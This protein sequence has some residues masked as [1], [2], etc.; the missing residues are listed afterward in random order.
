MLTDRAYR[1]CESTNSTYKSQCGVEVSN[2]E[3]P[4]MMR[5]PN[6]LA[7]SRSSMEK[8]EFDTLVELTTLDRSDI[9]SKLIIHCLLSERRRQL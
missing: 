7:A 5:F 2:I 4:L 8:A 3:L 1:N 9:I 6:S